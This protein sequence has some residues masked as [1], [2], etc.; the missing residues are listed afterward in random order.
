MY[1]VSKDPICPVCSLYK[2]LG[3]VISGTKV[4]SS[5]RM[6]GMLYEASV[7]VG[8]PVSWVG[9]GS[10]PEMSQGSG[11]PGCASR[12]E[13]ASWRGVNTCTAIHLSLTHP[14]EAK[15]GALRTPSSS[16]GRS[17]AATSLSPLKHSQKERREMKLLV[18][19]RIDPRD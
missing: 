2:G 6:A 10:V 16:A 13:R 18:V 3:V 8:N 17:L 5:E 11:L 7:G 19:H 1:V 15:L 4:S 12:R 14:I 9:R